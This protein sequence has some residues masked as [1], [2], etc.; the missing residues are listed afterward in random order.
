MQRPTVHL[1][2]GPVGA[3]KSTFA[4]ALSQQHAAVRLNLDEW[5]ATLFS[6]DRPT[7]GVMEWYAARTA[8]CIDQIWRITTGLVGVGSNV[9]LE[10]GL[11]R[12]ADRDDFYTRIDAA[13][14]A[15]KVYV[16][17][18]PRD[19]RRARVEARNLEKGGTFSMVVP[20]HIFELASDLWE[21]PDDDEIA[22]R[23]PEFISP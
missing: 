5:M 22:L 6:A 19:V 10:I 1:V 15:L 20:A 21:P 7:T 17:D 12:R 11:I 13:G 23:C 2:L 18:A 8:R 14:T 4:L 9:V 3:G 16:L